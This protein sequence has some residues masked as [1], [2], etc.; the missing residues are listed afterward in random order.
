[1]PKPRLSALLRTALASGL[2]V[3]CN[4]GA[5]GSAT[6]TAGTDSDSDSDSGAGTGS[7]EACGDPGAICISPNRDVDVLFIIDN[8]GSMAEEQARLAANFSSFIDVLEDPRVNADYRIAI[9]T[10]DMGNPA[11]TGGSAERGALV[12][13][14]CRDRVD[15]GDFIFEGVDPPVDAAYACTDLCTKT[16]AELQLL[17]TSTDKDGVDKPRPWIERIY[18]STNLP[19]GVTTTEAFQCFGPQGISGCGFESPLE[20]LVQATGRIAD[21][22]DPS[23]GFLRDNALLSIVILTDELDCSYNP[24]FSSIFTNNKVFWNDPG[25]PYATSAACWRAGVACDN[26]GPDYGDCA[27]E[28]YDSSGLPGADPTDAVLLPMSRFI[29][30]IQAIED[31]KRTINADA[32]VFVSVI[33]GVPEGYPA[34]PL[35]YSGDGD[36][37]FIDLYGV[38]PGCSALAGGD[39]LPPVRLREFAEALSIDGEPNLF[40]ICADD[41]SP[42]LQA[43]AE[44]MGDKIKPACIPGCVADSDPQT[45]LVEPTCTFYNTD[46]ETKEVTEIPACTLQGG[47]W[48]PPAPATICHRV[49]TDDD[50]LTPETDDDLSDFCADVGA[51]AELLLVNTGGTKPQTTYSCELAQDPMTTCPG[52]G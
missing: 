1:M 15:Q 42:A 52:L 41:Y 7:P 3:A 49:L 37:G 16:D 39:A 46:P 20:S 27:A 33:A 30:Q 48:L 38:A 31:A 9:T 34:T 43:I 6:A 5:E 8:S 22:D 24:E 11:C 26:P 36:E 29:D 51:N 2:V 19:A 50:D 44:R 4:G 10:T 35:I 13:S 21:P 40:S 23:Y 14:S 18:G 12:L 25:D 32:E 45:P 28:N 47:E 17:P